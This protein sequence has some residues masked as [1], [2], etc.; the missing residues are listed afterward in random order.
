MSQHPG[1]SLR[2][3]RDKPQEHIMSDIF[4]LLEQRVSAHQFAGSKL[5]DTELRA[6][7]KAATHSPTAYNLQNWHFTAVCSEAM[8]QRLHEA[9]FL[10]PKILQA[11]AVIVIS[12][13]L[14][15]HRHLEDRL[16]ASGTGRSGL[17]RD[18]TYQSTRQSGS[19]TR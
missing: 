18:C 11:A 15:G 1:H 17:A 8:K 16:L 3:L 14:Q 7:V 4:Q 13:D 2:T 9:A 12:G 10:Q 6:M 5:S 19:T